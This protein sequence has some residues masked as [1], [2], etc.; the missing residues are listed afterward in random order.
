MRYIPEDIIVPW[1]YLLNDNYANLSTSTSWQKVEKFRSFL[2]VFAL[3]ANGA[4]SITFKIQQAKDVLGSSA[5]DLANQSYTLA[6]PATTHRL[7]VFRFISS[8]LDT[9]N[10]YRTV[11]LRLEVT[12]GTST[13]VSGV[14]YGCDPIEGSAWTNKIVEVLN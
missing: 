5:K 3:G 10:G 6:N 7:I 4:T 2:A 13:Y 9:A 14:L 1:A 12:G 8:D 11:R